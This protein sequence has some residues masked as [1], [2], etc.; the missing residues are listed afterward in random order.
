MSNVIGM[1]D[2]KVQKLTKIKT[3]VK[4][5]KMSD[6]ALERLRKDLNK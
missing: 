6:K 2:W 5:G 4:K 3:A 1:L